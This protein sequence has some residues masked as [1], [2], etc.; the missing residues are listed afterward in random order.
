MAGDN[1]GKDI[2]DPV[3]ITPETDPLRPVT[4]AA[5][6]GFEAL[7]T[8]LGMEGYEILVFTNNGAAVDDTNVVR[9]KHEKLRVSEI[10]LTTPD[11][12][13]ITLHVGTISYR[14][15]IGG[16]TGTGLFRFAFPIVIERGVDVFFSHDG[17]GV[18][19]HYIIGRPE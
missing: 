4:E 5:Q 12:G 3:L 11:S 17:A 6:S 7:R 15:N 9:S 10:I 2:G 8:I 13:V 18:Q 16:T 14:F 1:G 19:D